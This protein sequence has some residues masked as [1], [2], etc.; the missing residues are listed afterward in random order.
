[1]R[2]A[3]KYHRVLSGLRQLLKSGVLGPGEAF[4]TDSEAV[5]RYGVSRITVRRAFSQ[6]EA[7]GLIER[8]PG[9][10]TF[11][12]GAEEGRRG[13]IVYIGAS[14]G[15]VGIEPIL[16]KGVDDTM[17]ERGY[18]LVTC[19]L[20]HSPE[21]ARAYLRHIGR[22]GADGVVFTPM[23]A[24]HAAN[25]EVL[26]YLRERHIPF[27]LVDRPMPEAPT[28]SGCVHPDHYEGGRLA[29]EHLA[30]LGHDR[31]AYLGITPPDRCGALSL[32]I[33]GFQDALRERGIAIVQPFFD[34]T[35]PTEVP[36]ALCK[37]RQE[38]DPPTAVFLEND[39][40]FP[41]L[42]EAASSLGVSIPGD[43]SVVGFDDLPQSQVGRAITTVNVPLYNEGQLAASLL[44]DMIE[45][46]PAPNREILLP[47]ALA[48]RGSTTI[49]PHLKA[50]S[51][52]VRKAK[53]ARALASAGAAK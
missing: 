16:V 53:P 33:K 27:V 37:W 21:R 13:L 25:V 8:I 7:D 29:G 48:I 23:L 40:L 9:K 50:G 30:D 20:N 14:I 41:P 43:L 5:E 39:L 31:I 36:V 51:G 44:M 28:G 11:V 22:M 18:N 52:K 4:L 46:K 12:R 49:S 32:R 10:G 47:V 6:L 3:I 19:H 2:P 24:E 38:S 26:D 35:R 1:M 17:S 34:I 15:S 42:A 45:G